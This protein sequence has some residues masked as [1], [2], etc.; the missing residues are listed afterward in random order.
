LHL[1]CSGSAEAFATCF[2]AA[3]Q[4]DHIVLSNGVSPRVKY[5]LGTVVTDGSDVVKAQVTF[6]P[7]G[8]QMGRYVSI[9]LDS[10]GARTLQRA[11]MRAVVASSP[12][13]EIAIIVDGRVAASPTVQ[14]VISNGAIQIPGLSE[15]AGRQL[16]NALTGSS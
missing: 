8:N 14:G 1:T 11:T 10:D 15:T 5:M 7:A 6:A 2:Q 16:A 12:Q 9:E 4:N 3:S 13:N